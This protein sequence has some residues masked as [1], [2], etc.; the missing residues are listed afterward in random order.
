MALGDYLSSLNM[1]P[2]TTAKLAG[3]AA[4]E[5]DPF[6]APTPAE[7]QKYGVPAADIAVAQAANAPADPGMSP[8][9]PARAPGWTPEVDTA[10]AVE[11]ARATALAKADP[12]GPAGSD[13]FPTYRDLNTTGPA[14]PAAPAAPGHMVPGGWQS[15][16]RGET[17]HLGM[18]P[19]EL[20]GA[21]EQ[22]EYA[23]KN[24]ETAG[25]LELQAAQQRGMAD[26]VYAA[27]H[28]KA[29]QDANAEMQRIAHDRA[30][31]V[32]QQRAKM[33][34]FSIAAQEK[35]DP[36]AARRQDGIAGYVMSAIAV[37][38]GQFGASMNGGPNAA[39][40]IVNKRIDE[41]IAAQ[42]D[43]IANANKQLDNQKG[44]YHEA[45]GE[46]GDQKSAALATKVAYLDQVKGLADQHYAL[47]KNTSNE[48]AYHE[49]QA[50]VADER[51]K[52]AEDLA[53]LKHTQVTT[54]GA[55]KYVPAHMVGGAAAG[56]KGK[57]ALY[58]PSL[59]G[60]A[61]DAETAR[62]LN[63]GGAMRMQ[64]NEDLH[65]VDKLLAE[66]KGLNS[67]TDYGRM[68]EIR[69]EIESRK[70]SVLQRTTVLRQQGAMSDGDKKV[71]EVGAQ[72]LNVDPQLK[73]AAQIERMRKGVKTVAVLHQQDHR[74]EGEANGI[75]LG[76]E[77][78]HRD[79]AG[80]MVPAA[81]L[82]GKNKIV[83]K[84][85]ES[86][87]DLIEKPKGVSDRK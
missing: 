36:D 51:G 79:A 57:E 28:T 21:E 82:A 59:Q 65:T 56:T 24:R 53:K 58:V 74:L 20:A 86:V 62:K 2:G 16:T 6:A 30:Q 73:T 39:L 7:M 15:S 14:T 33:E 43:N 47:A 71:A 77:E 83:T 17:R 66:A 87:D 10:R 72:L 69:N 38:L 85:T 46:F 63:A 8:A 40:Q 61:R 18:A 26:A 76:N 60:Y 31:Y 9:A 1:D 13:G 44:L 54:Q 23:A 55:E 41:R 4:P 84:K 81:R 37:G 49:F 48:A 52:T 68:Q 29:S 22:R 80:N 35:V 11:G 27:A 70:N 19:G 75:Q 32:Q 34:A 25:G 78:Y 42:R 3:M 67:I 5:V 50:K 45:L 64:I 12:Q